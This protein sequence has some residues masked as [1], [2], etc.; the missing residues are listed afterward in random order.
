RGYAY[1]TT[2]RACDSSASTT[3]RP[4]VDR[5][6]I[7]GTIACGRCFA[8]PS[9][10]GTGKPF[11]NPYRSSERMSGRQLLEHARAVVLDRRDDTAL[12]GQ[13][14]DDPRRLLG[15]ELLSGDAH[16]AAAQVYL[17]LRPFLRGLIEGLV[18]HD[19]ERKRL[20]DEVPLVDEG[21][22]LR[23]DRLDA[24]ALE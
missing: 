22:A 18:V 14:L 20:V 4:R 12:A 1:T 2:R 8:P 24:G 13:R 21:V 19:Q 7:G 10:W 3:S 9:S 17:D 6:A 11:G 5:S 23:H 16:A 15:L